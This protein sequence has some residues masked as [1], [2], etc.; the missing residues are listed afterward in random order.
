MHTGALDFLEAVKKLGFCVKLDTNGCYPRGLAAILDGGLADYIA[1]DIKNR[2]EKYAETAGVPTFS[3]APIEESIALL[4]QS[5]I[6]H[7][8]RT[9]VVREFHTV[10][11]IEAIARWLG[12]A[13]AYY[14][15]KFQD[16]G[17][18]ID[19]GLHSVCD[20]DMLAMK[21]AAS[22]WLEH[23]ELRGV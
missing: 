1:M 3:L 19:S 4:R 9:T 13:P 18:L 2:R 21:H 11:D 8:F 23:V 7:E 10:D 16:S 15:Q 20:A 17:N 5:S 12:S 22:R 6:P 14:L